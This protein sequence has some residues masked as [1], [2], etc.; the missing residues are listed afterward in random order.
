MKNV[1][2]QPEMWSCNTKETRDREL[3]DLIASRYAAKDTSP[4]VFPARRLRLTQTLK[5]L[6]Q[7]YLEKA[8]VLEVGCGAGFA[9]RYLPN[10]IRSYL[11]IDYSEV[12]IQIA[13]E[14]NA[15]PLAKF[16]QANAKS[17]CTPERFDVIF[18]IGVLHHLEQMHETVQNLTQLLSPTGWIVAN[19]PQPGNPV[20]HQLRLLRKRLDKDYSD[21]QLELSAKEIK[22][23]F[24]A[25]GLRNIICRPQ[26][27]LSTPFAEVIMRPSA[28]AAPLSHFACFV[29]RI[30]EPVCSRVMP[31]ISWNTIVAGQAP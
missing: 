11:G 31:R 14:I 15:H 23:C 16:R 21:E 22:R 5:I 2:N 18:L 7:N 3:F 25:C 26:G 24:L 4:S 1:S 9:V 20:I 10:T 13:Q 19:E 29:D 27:L 6:P 12:L 17:F 28:L 8:N 30:A